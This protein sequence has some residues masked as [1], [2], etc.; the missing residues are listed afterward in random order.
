MGLRR[1]SAGRIRVDGRE[2][3]I[4]SAAGAVAAGI[5]YLSEDGQG[6]GILTS[7]P[8]YA[9]VTLA[10]LAAYARPLL[11]R[12]RELERTRFY[13]DRF[14][15]KARSDVYAFIRELA[16]R[17]LAVLFISSELEEIMCYAT[18]IKEGRAQ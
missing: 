16:D 8:V 4:R 18:G 13:V 2:L 7:F 3:R 5:A 11:S 15:V 10:S 17:G 14:D 6:S 1:V 9:N 12:T